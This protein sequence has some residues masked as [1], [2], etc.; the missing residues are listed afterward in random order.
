MRIEGKSPNQMVKA[1]SDFPPS[2][3]RILEPMK[4]GL[5]GIKAKVI[6]RMTTHLPLCSKYL[7]E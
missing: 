6:L 1:R 4:I 5:E 2:D 7:S 3:Y